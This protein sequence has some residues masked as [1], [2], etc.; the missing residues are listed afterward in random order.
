MG[1]HLLSVLIA[2][3]A[4]QATEREARGEGCHGRLVLYNVCVL[5]VVVVL[6]P[7]ATDI[8]VIPDLEDVGEA[9]QP[10][11]SN[12]SVASASTYLNALS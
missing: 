2:A 6:N 8:P 9:E 3:L 7:A 12:V 1:V 5:V 10:I 11:Q 4:L